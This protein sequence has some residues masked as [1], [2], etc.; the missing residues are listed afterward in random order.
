MFKV[1]VHLLRGFELI[2]Q[3][4]IQIAPSYTIVALIVYLQL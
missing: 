3:L 2:F 4:K 1:C